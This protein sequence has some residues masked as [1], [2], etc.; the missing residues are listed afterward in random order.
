MLICFFRAVILYI[1][2]ILAIRLMGKRQLGQMEATEFV[3][4]ML[5]ADLAAVPMQD[6]SIPLLDGLIPI[7][8]VLSIELI[9]SVWIYQSIVIRRFFCGKPVI[10]IENGQILQQNMKKTRV[11]I[12]E[13]IEH[14]RLQGIV[15]I[16]AV[17]Y[18]ILETNG[19]LSVLPHSK[20]TPACAADA[21]IQV[22]E[23]SLPYTL[24]CQGRLMRENLSLAGRTE[25]WVESQLQK[26][27]CRLQDVF[28]LSADDS[29]KLYLSLKQEN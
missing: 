15:D 11:N 21:G 28:L 12:N 10:L 27:N 19:S 9:L 1:T 25:A 8:V 29:G 2:L 20:Y 17:R 6:E 7:F 3:V 14:L 26:H 13:L 5:I 23:T 18:A 4:T 16:S 22:A 24:V